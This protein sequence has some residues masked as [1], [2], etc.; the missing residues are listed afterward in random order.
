[1]K[2]LLVKTK[3]IDTHYSATILDENGNIIQ[4][5]IAEV[6]HLEIIAQ[7]QGSDEE[8]AQWRTGE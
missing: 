2:K 6:S 8:L 4:E 1:M 7:T 3:I 5:E